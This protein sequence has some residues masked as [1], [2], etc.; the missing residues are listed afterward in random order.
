MIAENL[1]EVRS[2]SL[3]AFFFCL[4]LITYDHVDLTRV[5]DNST[6]NISGKKKKKGGIG[7]TG[8]DGRQVAGRGEKG[9]ESWSLT[10]AQERQAP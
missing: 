1:W 7:Y 8:R 6:A 10:V 3:A 2:I 5:H 9:K 4:I